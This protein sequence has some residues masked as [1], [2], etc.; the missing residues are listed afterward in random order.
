MMDI[1]GL[2]RLLWQLAASC[3]FLLL[4]LS[5]RLLCFFS[6]HYILLT[7]SIVLVFVGA[8]QKTEAHTRITFE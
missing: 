2:F 6:L 3:F 4:L 8:K 5:H 7:L 1:P